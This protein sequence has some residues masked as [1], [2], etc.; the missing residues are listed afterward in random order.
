MSTDD[1]TQPPSFLSQHNLMENQV[2]TFEISFRSNAIWLSF[3]C[4]HK[5]SF[6]KLSNL[7]KYLSSAFLHWHHTCLLVSFSGALD[8]QTNKLTNIS[9]FSQAFEAIASSSGGMQTMMNKWKKQAWQKLQFD[10]DQIF[11]A[12]VGPSWWHVCCWPGA[13]DD[14]RCQWCIRCFLI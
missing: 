11:Q 8:K 14:L 13:L 5:E 6:F 1:N 7:L 12:Q 9:V 3:Y 10:F 4:R 2:R